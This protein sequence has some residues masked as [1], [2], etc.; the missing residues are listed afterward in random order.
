[1]NVRYAEVVSVRLTHPTAAPFVVF[2]TTQ[3]LELFLLYGGVEQS[4]FA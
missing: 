1:M 3:I 2:E 4:Q